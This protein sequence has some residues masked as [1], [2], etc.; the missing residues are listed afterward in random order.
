MR[1]V[2]LDT[3][4]FTSLFQGD[5][6]ILDAV[7]KADSVGSLDEQATANSTTRIRLLPLDP[8]R[9]HPRRP[10]EGVSYRD[11]TRGRASARR[12]LRDEAPWMAA[13]DAIEK[14]RG[15]GM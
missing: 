4:A 15:A 14:P 2:L 5:E 9:V 8:P 12:N 13:A 3:N 6:G 10:T 7:A 1:A 11:P